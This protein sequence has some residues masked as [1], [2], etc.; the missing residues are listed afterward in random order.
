MP[1][2]SRLFFVVLSIGAAIGIGNIFLYPYFR[3]NFSIIFFVPYIIALVFIC[4]P[5]LMLEFASGQYFDKNIIDLFASI[6]KWFSSIGWLMIINSF[7]LMGVI[8]SAA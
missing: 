2:N 5:L 7:I 1:N 3:F 4:V 8:S 6:R